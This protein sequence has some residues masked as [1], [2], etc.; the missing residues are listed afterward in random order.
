MG[1]LAEVPSSA[2]VSPTSK[3]RRFF[4]SG[5]A[6]LTNITCDPNCRSDFQLMRLRAPRTLRAF[7]QDQV[8]KRWRIRRCRCSRDGRGPRARRTQSL[9]RSRVGV[10]GRANFPPS[11]SRFLVH[12]LFRARQAERGRA[13]NR[14]PT[15]RN[16]TER[17]GIWWMSNLEPSILNCL[18]FRSNKRFAPF[19]FEGS[20]PGASTKPL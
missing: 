3:A 9:S 16:E 17:R 20:I 13:P 15:P 19:L 18:F 2:K 7:V 10:Q 4:D 5:A 1:L 8:L 14:V 6:T 12:A 11:S